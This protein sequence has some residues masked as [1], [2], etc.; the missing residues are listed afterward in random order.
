MKRVNFD[1]DF[2]DRMFPTMT[3]IYLAKGVPKSG[4]LVGPGK[5]RELFE[6]SGRIEMIIGGNVGD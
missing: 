3:E 5:I 2:E 4:I 6:I 1:R